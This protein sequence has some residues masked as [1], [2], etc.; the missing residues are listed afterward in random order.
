MAA[1]TDEIREACDLMQQLLQRP[2]PGPRKR[3]EMFRQVYKTLRKM[4]P[5]QCGEA[6]EPPT[7]EGD[8]SDLLDD[9]LLKFIQEVK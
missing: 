4:L 6:Q 8:A 3:Q 2:L 1:S 5:A 9:P 7:E